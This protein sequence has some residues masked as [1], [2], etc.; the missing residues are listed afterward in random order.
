MRASSSARRSAMTFEAAA[1]FARTPERPP[2]RGKVL[3]PG[4]EKDVLVLPTLWRGNRERRRDGR[5]RPV[6]RLQEGLLKLLGGHVQALPHS[7]QVALDLDQ[8]GLDRL[9]LLSQLVHQT[10]EMSRKTWRRTAT[11]TR[12]RVNVMYRRA[13]SAA[14]V[15]MRA[16]SAGVTRRKLVG[17]SR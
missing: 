13:R 8:T 2:F 16:A 10:P 6:E 7:V 11:A 15:A 9:Q 14:C 4:P 12:P 5:R 17:F 3:R 1:A